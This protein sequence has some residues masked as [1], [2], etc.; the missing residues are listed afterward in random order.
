MARF[1][2]SGKSPKLRIV[3]DRHDEV[4]VAGREYLVGHYVGMCVAKPAWR[5]ARCEIVEA[6]IDQPG[7]LGVQQAH[8]DVLALAGAIAVA[9]SG[10]YSNRYVKAT[11]D[12]GDGDAYLHRWPISLA[13]D[14]HDA[15]QT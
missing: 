4:A 3:T 9:K 15:T 7:H 5:R 6:L 13:G 2:E 12:V 10:H 14:A 8:V 11:D 1:G